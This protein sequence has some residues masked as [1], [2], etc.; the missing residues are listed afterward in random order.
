MGYFN[1]VSGALSIAPVTLR[2]LADVRITSSVNVNLLTHLEYDRVLYLFDQGAT[3]KQAKRIAQQEIL[4][5][6]NIEV[7]S[8]DNSEQLDISHA[9]DGN[10]ILLAISAILQ[11]NKSEAQLTELL[12]TIAGDLR[13]DGR[14]DSARVQQTLFAAMEYLKPRR[15]AIRSNIENRY[16]DL[17]VAAEIPPFEAYVFELDT[18]PPVVD[19]TE[20]SEGSGLPVSRITITF[21]ELMEHSTLTGQA[22]ALTKDGSPVPGTITAADSP[23]DTTVTFTSGAE[24]LPGAYLLTIHTSVTDYAGNRLA[25]QF[26]ISF[27]QPTPTPTAIPTPTNTPTHTATSTPTDTPSSTPTHTPTDTPSSTST[28]TPT[29]TP[30]P[31]NTPTQTPTYT[32]T[33]TPTHTPTATN[34]PTD[35]PTSTPTPTDTPTETPTF[36]PT[37][38]FTSTPTVTPTFTPALAD[39]AAEI[40]IPAGS[41]LMGC[42]PDDLHCANDEKPL[43]AVY[44]SAYFFDKYEVTNFRYAACVSAGGCTAPHSAGSNLRA[45]YYSDIAY[46]DYPVLNVDWSQAQ[47]F[48]TWDGKRLP[49]EAEWEKAA[50]GADDTR[51]YPWGDQPPGPPQVYYL[52]SYRDT[53][54]V[55]SYPAGA[56]PY[57]VMDLGG[58]VWEWVNDWYNDAYYPISPASDPKGPDW[59]GYRSARG[60]SWNTGLGLRAVDRRWS[61]PLFWDSSSGF[62][63]ARTQPIPDTPTPGPTPIETPT[64]T[65]TP[66]VTPTATPA[67]ADPAAQILV[68]AGSFQMGCSPNDG[69][70]LNHELPLHMVFLSAYYIDKYEV[71]NF[72]Y[73]TCVAAGACTAPYPKGSVTRYPYYGNVAYG[74]YPVINVTWTQA[75]A[76]CTWDGKRLPSEAEWEKAARGA[77]DTRIY[78]WGDQVPDDTLLNFNWN[79]GDTTKVG[80][81]PAGASPFGVMDMS[82]NVWEWVNDRYGE[83]YYAISPS[84]NPQGPATGS[85]RIFR[86]GCFGD[87]LT[88]RVSH[89]IVYSPPSLGFYYGFRCARS[90]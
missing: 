57:G 85:F 19:F 75:Q 90:Q 68:P 78:P 22:I 13:V 73:A 26:L 21:S 15:A 48:C 43:H 52:Y 67:L 24:L 18:V 29:D 89:R 61:D 34:S 58:N 50:R 69:N 36:T 12:S 39:A 8:I 77:D 41:F 49:T 47:A 4:D 59:G 71:T 5:A 82:G 44:L 40:L 33:P 76:F 86:G 84:E 30:T 23:L 88:L 80:S 17:G 3:V 42:S 1:E 81:Y 16:M 64:H 65:P 46:G 66:T 14:L 70:C 11:D 32:P 62:R 51:I 2:G 83:Y 35:T 9:G 27:A 55:G 28:Y 87:D 74:D 38:T 6:F 53:S 79:A 37:P 25:K 20:P 56:S 60:G 7:G 10:A 63:C 72:R 45:L 54:R 31:T